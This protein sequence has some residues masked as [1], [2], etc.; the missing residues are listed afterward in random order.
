MRVAWTIVTSHRIRCPRINTRTRK[1]R[2]RR[3]Q[4]TQRLRPTRQK[5]ANFHFNLPPAMMGLMTRRPSR[6]AEWP[7]APRTVPALLFVVLLFVACQGVGPEE[8]PAAT[9]TRLELQDDFNQLRKLIDR[10]HPLYF[11]DRAVLDAAF[12]R[13]QPLFREGM[14]STEFLRTI[15][16]AVSAVRCGHTRLSLPRS[17]AEFHREH[18]RYLPFEIRAF[19]DRSLHVVRSYL[20]DDERVD[21]GSAIVS[22]NGEPAE[23]IVAKIED[24]LYADG[25]NRTFKQFLMNTD[26]RSVYHNCVGASETF[27]VVLRAPGEEEASTR[28]FAA[29]SE[30]EIQGHRARN[31]MVDRHPALL[32]TSFLD[33][34]P[35]AL[36]KIGFFDFDDDLDAFSHRIERFFRQIS[37]RG[38]GSL[39]LDL[40]GNDGG[41]PYSA[42]HLL[43]YLIGRPFRYYSRRSTFLFGDLKKL[44]SVPDHPFNGK[45]YVLID[46]GSYSTTGH[47]IS[48]LKHHGVGTFIG[49]ESGGSYACNG[50]Y[51]EHRLRH[52]GIDL[53]LPH[54]TFITEAR[55]LRRGR[56]IQPDHRVEPGIRDLLSGT[57]PAMESAIALI[58]GEQPDGSASSRGWSPSRTGSEPSSTPPGRHSWGSISI[59]YRPFTG[60]TMLVPGK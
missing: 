30:N 45:L 56:G 44:Q 50:G 24:C 42:A 2:K 8:D 14:T 7:F 18:G 16:P 12:D 20:G 54:T 53:L 55:G 29:K 31:G 28:V 38:T 49:V 19:G 22:I 34:P 1:V 23:R 46:G 10:R 4:L 52:T 33:E 13:Q 51:K 32:T 11:T 5:A 15:A 35:H 47:F 40:R 43:G 9:Y 17:V 57:D 25:T 6:S 58:R 39:I 27:T 60:P 59:P 37:D 48:L 36:M 21:P 26:F 41:G 3:F